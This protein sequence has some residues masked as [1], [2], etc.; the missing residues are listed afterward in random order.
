MQVSD[1]DRMPGECQHVAS[2][3]AIYETAAK[4]LKRPLDDLYL[5]DVVDIVRRCRTNKCQS[6]SD[7]IKAL[8]MH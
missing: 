3:M 7:H 1:A 8:A 5:G 4:R 2:V 6:L